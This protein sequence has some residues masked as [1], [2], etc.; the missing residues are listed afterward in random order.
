MENVTKDSTQTTTQESFCTSGLNE[1]PKFKILFP[2]I[3]FPLS[4]TAFLGNVLILVALP[5]VTSLH[6]SSK[7][8]LSCLAVTDL[9]V[10][11]TT[12]PLYI[13]YSLLSPEHSRS[14]F[15]LKTVFRA[16]GTILVLLSVFTLTAISIDRLLTLLSGVRYR[17]IVTLRRVRVLVAIFWLLSIS[18]SMTLFYDFRINIFIICIVLLLG[19]LITTFCYSKIYWALL[20]HQAQVQEHLHQGQPN[21]GGIPLNIARYKKSVSSTLCVTVALLACYLPYGIIV[22]VFSITGTRAPSLNLAWAFALFLVFFNSTLNPFLYCWKIREVRQAV[23]ETIRNICCS[24][25]D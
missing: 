15:F 19:V 12:Q 20:H 3:N 11:L 8:L 21:G 24:S 22:A 18:S 6:P 1:I 14:C 4:F 5:K 10:G 16:T 13:S 25:P 9:C 2:I 23:R 7:L 17:Q